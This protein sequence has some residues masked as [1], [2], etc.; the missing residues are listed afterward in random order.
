MIDSK[1]VYA[2]QHREDDSDDVDPESEEND[3]KEDRL[4][5]RSRRLIQVAAL[6]KI[7]FKSEKRS[8]E[9]AAE[10]KK[11]KEFRSGGSKVEG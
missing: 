6:L 1:I 11:S 9:G 5:R 4:R 7:R 3:Q 2:S 10:A 8:R